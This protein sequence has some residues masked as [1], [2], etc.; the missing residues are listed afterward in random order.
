MGLNP[1]CRIPLVPSLLLDLPLMSCTR[2][3]DKAL[4]AQH[5]SVSGILSETRGT[6]LLFALS[7]PQK[8]KLQECNPEI[9]S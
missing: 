5:L 4:R 9:S 1:T 8:T 3:G 2:S 7:L 6:D